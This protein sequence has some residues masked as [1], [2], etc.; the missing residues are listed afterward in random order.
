MLER[1]LART[2]HDV[3]HLCV[4]EGC[5]ELADDRDTVNPDHTQPFYRDTNWHPKCYYEKFGRQA[6]V[7]RLS[8]DNQNKFRLCDIP[9]ELM[10]EL[11]EVKP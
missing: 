6:V 11:L 3:R 9:A 4:C 1:K 5:K 10:R 2:A 8:R 7:E